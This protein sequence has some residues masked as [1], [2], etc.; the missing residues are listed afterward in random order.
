MFKAKEIQYENFGRCLEM[1]NE[2]I[3][4]V[5]TLDFGPRVICYS[6]IDGENI[7]FEDSDRVFKE[8][9]PKMEEVYGI[10]KPW[11]IYGGHRLWKSPETMPETY[12]PDNDPVSYKLTKNGADFTPPVQQ[13]T[14]YG[15]QI[16]ITLSENESNL[17]VEH[18]VTNYGVKNIDISIWPITV[19]SPGGTEIIPQ[20]T[21]KTWL[22]PQMRMAFWDYVN[23]TDNR[24]KW[25][26]RYIILKQDPNADGRIKFGINNEHGFAM[27]FNHGDMFLKEFDVVIDGNYPDGGMCFETYTN[28]LFLE[29]E[30]LGELKSVRAGETISHT[31]KW[32]LYKQDIPN[33]VDSDIDKLKEKYIDNEVRE[34]MLNL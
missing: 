25:L 2:I 17:T 1:S 11:V 18:K 12:Y 8:F 34:K 30:S 15:Y 14:N 31:E 16:G 24:L 28:P 3:R 21:R 20:P 19:L 13:W 22:A 7:F 6:F 4:I 32:S 10:N 26:E 27:Y 23:M 9:N 5:V 29:M 33:L